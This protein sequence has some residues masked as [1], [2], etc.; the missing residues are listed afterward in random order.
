MEY[1]ICERIY[2]EVNLIITTYLNCQ[3][4]LIGFVWFVIFWFSLIL[5]KIVWIFIV[6]KT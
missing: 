6:H 4:S 5:E 1:V 2:S 3:L